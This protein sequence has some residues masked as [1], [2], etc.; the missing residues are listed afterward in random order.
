MAGHDEGTADGASSTLLATC[1]R[2]GDIVIT[3]ATAR[4]SRNWAPGQAWYEFAC[5]MCTR[6]TRVS[7]TSQL[8]NTLVCLGAQP[9]PRPRHLRLLK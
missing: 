9:A 6:T 4:V 8:L 7:A 5:P 1:E 3:V 2:C